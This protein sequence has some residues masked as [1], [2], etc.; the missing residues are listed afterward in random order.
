MEL[1]GLLRWFA[2]FYI[3]IMLVFNFTCIFTGED[4]PRRVASFIG[5]IF[6]ALTMY[7]VLF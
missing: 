7:F 5:T 6:S 1:L 3:G 2:I 4:V